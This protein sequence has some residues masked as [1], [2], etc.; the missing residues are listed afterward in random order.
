MVPPKFAQNMP[1]KQIVAV[2]F[3]SRPNV[4]HKLEV[5]SVSQLK[6]A[7][8]DLEGV[9]PKYQTLSCN[10]VDVNDDDS[11]DIFE[12]SGDDN[13]D[14]IDSEGIVK[15]S[16]QGLDGG[17]SPYLRCERFVLYLRFM[18]CFIGADGQ[19]DECQLFCVKCGCNIS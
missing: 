13:E 2:T 18:C 14:L 5:S 7:I 17:K 12:P 19:W 8:W 16:Y 15:C 6:Q 11:L 4:V 1:E 3:P 10:G 9:P